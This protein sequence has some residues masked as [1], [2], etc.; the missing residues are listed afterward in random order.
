MAHQHDVDRFNRWAKT[1]D[2]HY[3]Q[4]R[5]FEPVHKTILQL[6]VREVAR[7]AAIL[8][9]GCGTGILLK[10]AQLRFPSAE[11][12]GIDAAIEMVRVAE[13]SLP[14]GSPIHFQEALAEE[15]PFSDGRFD[16][17]FSTMTFHHWADQGKGIAEVARVLAPGGRWLLA[18]FIPAGALAFVRRVLRLRQFPE[19][20]QLEAALGH[21][22]LRV[23]FELRAPGLGGQ[24]S[25]L[26]IGST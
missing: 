3:L 16:L 26:A 21:E 6:A 13:A 18:E 19:R 14:A 23:V 22:G 1:Y 25:V 7:P 15:L 17:V 20:P 24:V 8:D 4:R 9:V 10:E 2:R 11:L 12:F 5:V